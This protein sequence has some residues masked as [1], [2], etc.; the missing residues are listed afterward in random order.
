MAMVTFNEAKKIAQEIVEEINPLSI[1]VFGSVAKEGCGND[2]DLFVVID[3]YISKEDAIKALHKR[4]KSYY[5]HFAI[6]E[7]VVH[8]SSLKKHFENGSPFIK[9]IIKEGRNIYM[10]EAIQEWM[11]QAEEELKTAMYLLEGGFFKGV[12]YHAQQCI[13]KAIKA[14]LLYKGWD[15]EKTHNINRLIALCNEYK[16]PIKLSDEEIAFIDSI[17]KGRYPVDIGLLPLGE[18]D[19]KDAQHAAEIARRILNEA[20]E[21][22]K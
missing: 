7:F 16:I 20:K 15:L 4:L 22:I 21:N 11:R 17:Y 19:A 10:K 6:D 3:D 9:L 14:N 5:T 1:V 8:R 2:L 13:E 12:C 18:P